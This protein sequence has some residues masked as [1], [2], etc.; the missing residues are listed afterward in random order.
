MVSTVVHPARS[1]GTVMFVVA[2]DQIAL[3]FLLVIFYLPISN[4]KKVLRGN[5][6]RR[7]LLF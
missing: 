3:Q 1:R 2:I 5:L 7:R 4:V 6:R